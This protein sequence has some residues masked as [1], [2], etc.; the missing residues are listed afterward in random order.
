MKKSWLVLI[1][2]TLLMTALTGCKISKSTPPPP[3]PAIETPFATSVGPDVMLTQAANPTV[4]VINPNAQP[5]PPPMQSTPVVLA[6]FTPVPVILPTLERPATYALQKG[7]WPICV[8]RRYNLDL[9][10]FFAANGLTMNSRPAVGTTLKIP[11][12]G[13]WNSGARALK[14]HPATYTV[15]SGDTIYTI[16][17]DFG[18]VDPNAIVVANALAAP[19]TLQAGQVLQI[20]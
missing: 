19:Y 2:V 8:A 3:T 16:A 6:T 5:T 12:T 1:L 20:P 14:T 10:T 4:A 18:D 9:D 13:T 7:E 15:K 11:A 17:C